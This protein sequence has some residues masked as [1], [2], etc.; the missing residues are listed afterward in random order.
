MNYIGHYIN[1]VWN[2]IIAKIWQSVY[3]LLIFFLFIAIVSGETFHNI[4]LLG[5]IRINDNTEKKSA[6]F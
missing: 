3:D 1:A 5:K 6:D 2:T 4:A